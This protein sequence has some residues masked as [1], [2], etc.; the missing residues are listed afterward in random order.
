[1]GQRSNLLLTFILLNGDVFS[2]EV[3]S[4]DVDI[5]LNTQDMWHVIKQK[6][7]N[8]QVLRDNVTTQNLVCWLM[9]TSWHKVPRD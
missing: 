7:K 2:Q 5:A 8:K 1:M 4:V 6:G 9:M 3:D